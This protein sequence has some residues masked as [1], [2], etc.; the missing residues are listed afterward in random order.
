M[1]VTVSCFG[2]FH[3]YYLAQ[4]LY[5]QHCLQKLIT[6]YPAR[7]VANYGIPTTHVNG[8]WAYEVQKRAA[9]KL[10]RLS[11]LSSLKYPRTVYEQFD[12]AASRRINTDS[13]VVVG[14]SGAAMRTLARAKQL[15]A[16][17][18]VERGS[19]HIQY[20]SEVLTEEMAR[21]NVPLDHPP[22]WIVDRELS[23]Y[24]LADAI[25]I[26]SSF[27]RRSFLAKGVS[28]EKL[29]QVPYGVDLSEFYPPERPSEKFRIVFA[30]GMSLRKGVHYLLRAF[31]ELNLPDAELWLFGTMTAEIEPFFK[32]YEGHYRYFGQVSQAE[33]RRH[34]HQCAVFTMCSLE[35]GMAMVQLQ[36][37]ASGLPLICTTNTGG[38]DLITDG[39]EG[40]VIPIRDVDALKER[41]MRLYENPERRIKMGHAA[42]ARVQQGYSWQNYGENIATA[43]KERIQA[44]SK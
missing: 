14:W 17:A 32:R 3:A 18:V 19:S 38:D 26:P 27:V 34:Y 41:L 28:A 21:H 42:Q 8:L 25:A 15:G 9:I 44:I 5:R 4:Q 30:G 7:H 39:T 33:L 35:E 36:A 1:N 23:E 43:Y 10:S 24:E 12:K 40:Y 31:A 2:K 16:L 13:D 6:S 37:M 29:I 11:M 22:Q 20:Q